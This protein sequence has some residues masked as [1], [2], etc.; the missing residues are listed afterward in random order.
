MGTDDENDSTRNCVST[1]TACLI[2]QQQCWYNKAKGSNACK[3]KGR[4]EG[5]ESNAADACY[6]QRT[7]EAGCLRSHRSRAGVA[8]LM[9]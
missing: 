5:V 4:E 2:R 3:K 8:V 6:E 9:M 1:S 7:A